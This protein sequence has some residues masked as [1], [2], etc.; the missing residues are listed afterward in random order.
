[1]AILERTAPE[2]FNT[3]RKVDGVEPVP[4][5]PT[6]TVLTVTTVAPDAPDVTAPE[7]DSG[8]GD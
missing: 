4:T 5:D 2:E 6:T 1:M 3:L 7:G 8:N